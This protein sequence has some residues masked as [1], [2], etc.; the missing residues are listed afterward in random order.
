MNGD[1]LGGFDDVTCAHINKPFSII[2]NVKNNKTSVKSSDERTRVTM[3][4][5]EVRFNIVT[6][7]QSR[8]S[9]N[10]WLMKMP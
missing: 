1:S 9:R 4:Q 10:I 8:I 2:I 6:L 7:L 3:G 5:N